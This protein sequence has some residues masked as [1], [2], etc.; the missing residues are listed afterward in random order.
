MN[1][2]SR[3]ILLVYTLLL[4]KFVV[5]KDM[6]MILV[7]HMRFYFGGT[8]T[9]AANWI[10]FKTIAEYFNGERGLLISGLNLAGNLVLLFP[11][12]FLLPNCFANLLGR[13]VILYIALIISLGIE[14]IQALSNIGIFDVDDVLLNGIGLLGGFG[15]YRLIPRNWVNPSTIAFA[16]LL[17]LGLLFYI[18]NS[19]PIS[20]R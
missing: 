18:T 2:L 1:Y 16:L 7:G 5:F 11:I 3:A 8:Q 4:I 6:D 19:A 15:A 9:G 10:P 13:K 12:G 20:N 17:S 14:T